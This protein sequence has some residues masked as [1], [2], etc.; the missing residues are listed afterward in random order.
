MPIFQRAI[1]R[2]RDGDDMPA[3]SGA[4]DGKVMTWDNSAQD[5]VMQTMSGGGSGAQLDAA[6]IFTRGQTI[7]GA[8][9]DIEAGGYLS[10]ESLSNNDFATGDLTDWTD[11]ASGWSVVAHGG[12]YA[13]SHTPGSTG[14]LTQDVSATAEQVYVLSFVVYGATVG[15]VEVYGIENLD[16]TSD[17]NGAFRAIGYVTSD[18]NTITVFVSD[19]F[20]GLI[21]NVSLRASAI[22]FPPNITFFDSGGEGVSEIR[23]FNGSYFSGLGAG[24]NCSTDGNIGIG[25]GALDAITI[26]QGNV[27]YGAGAGT[28][29]RTNGSWL[30]GTGAGAGIVADNEIHAGN[31]GDFMSGKMNFGDAATQSLKFHARII[32]MADIPTSSA[33]LATGDLWNDSGVLKIA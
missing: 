6:N 31:N 27:A 29:A 28:G 32:N 1:K 9:A 5:W 11:D 22:G 12:G 4:D 17:G 7:Q 15:S 14:T 33:G 21:E 26:E 24:K 16:V 19:D 13:L 2:V 10:P 25:N 20:D 18:P 8:I 3:L 23:T 30:M